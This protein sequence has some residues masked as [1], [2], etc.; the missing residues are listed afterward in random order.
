MDS[1]QKSL[2]LTDLNWSEVRDH[3]DRDRR[4]II[5]VGA[6][7]Q[8]GPH[9]PLG[10]CTLI[11]EAFA[12]RLSE[13]CSVLRAPT[14]PYGVNVPAETGFPGAA[15]L[16]EKTL[17][18]LLNDLLAAWEDDGFD[19]FILLTVHDYDSHVEAIATASTALSRV[20][21]VE[22]LNMDLSEIIA[23]ASVAQHGG[24]VVTSLMLHLYPDR[25]R[26]ER[27]I[28][29]VAEGRASSTVRRVP[30]IPLA[31]PGS[32]GRPTLATAETGRRLYEYIL[33]KILTRV[34]MKAE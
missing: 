8:Y 28:D 15:T 4:L 32:L 5:P 30:S 16:R 12:R 6:C 7:D 3:L 11:S 10:A 20:R 33:E 18:G 23:D 1:D 19:E 26:M 2:I 21:V 13:E 34:M 24:E 9:L 31:S 27:A 29:Y 25:V 22:V 14:I 17:H